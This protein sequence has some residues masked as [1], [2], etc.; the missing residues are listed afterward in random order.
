MVVEFW[1][2]VLWQRF[3]IGLPTDVIYGRL[4]I[5][6]LHLFY[7]VPAIYYANRSFARYYHGFE[8][9][10]LSK[11]IRL[12]FTGFFQRCSIIYL[13]VLCGVLT[14]FILMGADNVRSNFANQVKIDYEQVSSRAMPFTEGAS[15]TRLEPPQSAAAE[16]L[17]M[18]SAIYDGRWINRFT[19]G[20]SLKQI[21]G[22]FA[23]YAQVSGWT[24]EQYLQFMSYNP[25]LNTV[26]P[27]EVYKKGPVHG[28]GHW[29]IT[30]SVFPRD[31][32][33]FDYE[34]LVLSS[35]E[36]AV[37]EKERTE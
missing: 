23:S 5:Y 35:F 4:G 9:L 31:H 17:R 22:H 8:A 30:N 10:A 37:E 34:A 13:P 36:Y 21:V 18:R 15:I 28:L 7:F 25:N 3:Q 33:Q 6:F 20:V 32:G 16:V 14:I 12:V 27:S 24:K 29:L 11:Y 2:I 1:L 26:L 19:D